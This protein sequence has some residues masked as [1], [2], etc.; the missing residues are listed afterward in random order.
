M[1][2]GSWFLFVLEYVRF[3]WEVF[4]KK[5]KFLFLYLGIVLV[6]LGCG[7]EFIIFINSIVGGLEIIGR[8]VVLWMGKC[9]LVLFGGKWIA[10]LEV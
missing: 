9:N 2:F 10:L 5:F 1:C 4:L 6:G 8:E 3:I 7:F